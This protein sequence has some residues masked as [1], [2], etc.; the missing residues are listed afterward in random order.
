[1]IDSDKIVENVVEEGVQETINL[2]KEYDP[3]QR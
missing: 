2:L 1:M 3:A